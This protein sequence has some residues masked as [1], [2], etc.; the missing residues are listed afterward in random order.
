M[1][2]KIAYI[3]NHSSFFCSHIIDIATQARQ[4]N[5]EIKLFCG[6][7]ASKKMEQNAKKIIKE[8]KILI[9]K[10]ISKSSSI[11]LIQEIFGFY[12]LFKSIKKY[13]PDIIH[14]ASPKGIIFGGLISRFL[15]IKSLVIFNS[16]MGFLFSN[17]IN[18]IFMI[19]KWGYIFLLKNYIMKHSN[20]RI[21]V[22]NKDDY[23]FLKNTYKI[24]SKEIQLIKGS[25]VNLKKY[26]YKKKNNSKL[27]M[28]PAR[29]IKEKG[30]E[31]FIMAAV[32]LNKNF[33]EWKFAVAG[34]FDYEKQSKLNMNR[35]K[36][37]NKNNIVK[38]LGYVKN[39]NTL[40]K[41]TAIVCLPSYREGFSRTLQEAAAVGIPIVTTNVVGCK[42]SII[43]NKT[44]LLSKPKNYN[45]LRKKL[46]ILISSK[47]KRLI[48][49]LNG[50]KLA[51]K[52]FELNSVIKKNLDIYN[53]LIR[54]VQKT[55]LKV[56]SK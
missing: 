20:K 28:L 27:V 38:F 44:G 46:A 47:K 25:G 52:E 50:R 56:K 49:G 15:N 16:G 54:S 51:E 2:K 42:D 5:Y 55:D 19:V 33:P 48:F 14:C 3:I 26:K 35:I 11:N 40:Y 29:V 18:L 13:K 12:Q 32:S 6:R 1:K 24:K 41:K 30:I 23:F 21:I 9:K 8:K 45:S 31:E 39:M 7:D 53:N 22:E 4:N 43:P 34:T 17:R 37:L 10:N 36:F